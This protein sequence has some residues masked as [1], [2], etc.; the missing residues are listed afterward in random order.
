MVTSG[1]APL[2]GY[3][4]RRVRRSTSTDAF[5][6]CDAGRTGAFSELIGRMKG[7]WSK[8]LKEKGVQG[9]A[10]QNGCGAFSVSQSETAAVILYITSQAEHQRKCSF[11]EE[12]SCAAEAA[13]RRI[14]FDERYVWD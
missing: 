3:A 14:S 5:Q 4:F 6:R 13:S 10:W 7:S 11:Q 1:T 2:I 12:G 9:F 8:R